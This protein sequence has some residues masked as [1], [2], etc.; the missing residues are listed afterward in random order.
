MHMCLRDAKGMTLT[1][2]ASLVLISLITWAIY[3]WVR[4]QYMIITRFVPLFK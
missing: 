1:S 2:Y 3:E 4:V